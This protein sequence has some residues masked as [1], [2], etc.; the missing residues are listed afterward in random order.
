[1]A[2]PVRSKLHHQL[3][4]LSTLTDSLACVE[5]CLHLGR[6]VGREWNLFSGAIALV[7]VHSVTANH[8]LNED[9]HSV[10]FAMHNSLKHK[11]QIC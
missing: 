1:M 5:G 11:S 10:F 7:T 2:D 3:V 6:G 8:D 9:V 4:A